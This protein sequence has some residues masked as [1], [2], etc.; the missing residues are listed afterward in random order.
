MTTGQSPYGGGGFLPD[1][2]QDSPDVANNGGVPQWEEQLPQ[3]GSDPVHPDFPA[4][5]W[6]QG[7]GYEAGAGFPAP[8]SGYQGQEQQGFIEAG[9]QLP[10]APADP[11]AQQGFQPGMF[12]SEPPATA[13]APQAG[14][15]QEPENGFDSLLGRFSSAASTPFPPASSAPD[16]KSVG[17]SH[18]SNKK[19]TRVGGASKGKPKAKFIAVG[20]VVAVVLGAGGVYVASAMNAPKTEAVQTTSGPSV[21]RP[22]PPGWAKSFAW[23]VPADVASNLAVRSDYIAYLTRS[24]VLVVVNGKDGS[25]EFSSTPTGADPTTAR[26]IIT[27]IGQTPVAVV[28]QQTSV[29]TWALN[30]ENPEPKSNDIP[31]SAVVSSGGSGVMVLAGTETWRLNASLGLE[32]AEGLPGGNTS[33]AL[34]PDGTIVSGSAKGGWSIND[35]KTSKAVTVQMAEGAEGKAMYPTR[36]AKGYVVA[37]APTA[38][39]NTRV[40]GLYSSDGTLVASTKMSTAQV[41]LGLALTVSDGGKLAAVGGWLVDLQRGETEMVDGWSTSISTSSEIFGKTSEGKAV[42]NGSGKP[43]VMAED[44]AVPWGITTEGK[45]IVISTDSSGG[46]VIAALNREG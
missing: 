46:K 26:V 23:S 38:D 22:V 24:G 42:W 35:G 16:P 9:S 44:V 25:T 10:A 40:V 8:A 20:A 31:S 12:S 1:W 29:T 4:P 11:Y 27:N 15:W 33:L 43:T 36:A 17:R 34:N 32:K 2:M 13:P 41:N 28:V 39:K 6:G 21:D 37:W 45:A 3:E 30:H 14:Q 7:Q 18:G 5:T 19:P